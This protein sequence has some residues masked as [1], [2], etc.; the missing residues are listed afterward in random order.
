MNMRNIWSNNIY[1]L[2]TI[3]G[4]A[5]AYGVSIIVEAIRHNLVNFLEQTICVFIILDA[6]EHHKPYSLV[7]KVI[8]LFLLIH[9]LA[10]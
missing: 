4:P 1:A 7:V 5:P 3:F 6:I 9:F 8:V 10:D 2:K